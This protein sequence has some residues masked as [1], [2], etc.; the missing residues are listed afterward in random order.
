MRQGGR[1]RLKVRARVGSC[2]R[3]ASL[4]EPGGERRGVLSSAVPHETCPAG[5]ASRGCLD[6]GRGERLDRVWNTRRTLRK[7]GV[8]LARQSVLAEQ[9]VEEGRADLVLQVVAY[10]EGSVH[11][12]GPS[13]ARF[14]SDASKLG[15]LIKEAEVFA[16][17]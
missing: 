17:T 12:E 2:G 9:L 6:H 10:L 1:R 16:P 11:I 13:V 14:Q 3:R 4:V 8:G 7:R 15:E 5:P